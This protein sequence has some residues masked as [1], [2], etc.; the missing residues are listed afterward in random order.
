MGALFALTVG[1]VASV[2]VAGIVD[3]VPVGAATTNP[4]KVFKKSEIQQAFGGTVGSGKKG[5]STAVS[6][7]CEFAVGANAERPAGTVIVKAMTTGAKAAYTGLK[8]VA[9]YAPIDGVPDSLSNDKLHVVEIL[10]GD[11]LVGV[12]GGF[13]ITDPLPIH[14]YDDK[15]QLTQLAQLA[16]K[17]I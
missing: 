9:D 17:R 14:F 3:V 6:S 2:G 15:T 10:H 7:Q 13:S 16:A 8:K 12:Q 1:V 5:I 11:V 4:C